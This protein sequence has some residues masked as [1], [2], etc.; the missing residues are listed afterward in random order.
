MFTTVS[1]PQEEPLQCLM[2]E[3]FKLKSINGELC[4]RG[5]LMV[6]RDF[7][8]Y[9]NQITVIWSFCSFEVV[10]GKS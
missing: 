4:P 1:T 2:R 7:F 6:R 8:N 5:T 3:H 9:Y 10:W